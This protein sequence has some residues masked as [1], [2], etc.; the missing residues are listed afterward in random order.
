MTGPAGGDSVHDG[1]VRLEGYVLWEAELTDAKVQAEAF[2]DRFE[3]LT[4]AQREEVVAAFARERVELS[5]TFL[6]RTA[7][8]A[9][10]LRDDYQRRYDRLR[11]KVLAAGL[12]AFASAVFLLL[13]L[14][15]V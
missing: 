6:E 15:Y 11:A 12:L 13:L 5:R 14:T 10:R 2:A 3:W 9:G 8:R 7:H 1:L 4:T